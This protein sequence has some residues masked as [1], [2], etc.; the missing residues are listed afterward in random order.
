VS[1]QAIVYP[2]DQ[3]VGALP[4]TGSLDD[5]RSALRDSGVADD[6]VTVHRGRGDGGELAPRT[7]D[8]DGL[9]ERVVRGAQ[10]VLGDE[11]ERLQVLEDRLAEGATLVCVALAADEDD[12]DARDREKRDIGGVL[13]AHGAEDVAF[14]G[15]YQ[16]EQLDASST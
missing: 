14:Y 8:A 9:K 10:K 16:I 7:E 3:V 12:D 5:L 2:T 15:K 13:R 6:A 1:D 11:A 4:A